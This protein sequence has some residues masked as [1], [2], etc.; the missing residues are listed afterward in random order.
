MCYHKSLI[1]SIDYLADYYSVE[2]ADLVAEQYTPHYH[3]NG[4]DFLPSPVVAA[5]NPKSFEMMNW[6]FIPWWVKSLP[7]GL[8]LRTQTLNCISEE[9]YDKPSFRDSAKDGKRCLIPCSG[10]FEWRW[11]DAKGKMKVP[12]YLTLP[13]QPVFSIAGLYS[14]WRDKQTEKEYHTY[15]VLTTMAN[16]LLEKIHNSKK[17]M[18]VILPR[19]HEKDWLNPNLTKADVLALCR[20]FDESPMKGY[21][22]SKLIT[23]KKEETDVPKVLAPATYEEV[24]D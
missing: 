3:E 18:P 12:Y 11:M 14:I 22:I 4:F 23:S 20:P 10:F 16:P 6:G 5:G 17:R 8:R 9:M 13:D 1:N 24:K 15:T 19:E 2:Y 7:D 21:T